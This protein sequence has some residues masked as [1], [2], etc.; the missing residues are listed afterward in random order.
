[1]KVRDALVE[2]LGMDSMYLAEAF[3]KVSD[4]PPVKTK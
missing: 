4:N 3:G 2:F 1:M